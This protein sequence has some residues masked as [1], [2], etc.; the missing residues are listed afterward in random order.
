LAVIGRYLFT[1]DIFE[2]LHHTKAG[3]GHE[4]QLTDAIAKLLKKDTV[5]AYL[6][7]SKRFDCG[8]KIGYIEAT[9]AYALKHPELKKE[10]KKL[11]EKYAAL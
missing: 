2:H 5:Y 6:S 9:L 10:V 7:E 8:S 1:P 3:T 4:I 11:L